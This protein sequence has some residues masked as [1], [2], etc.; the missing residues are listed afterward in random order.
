MLLSRERKVVLDLTTT[1]TT[2][3]PIASSTLLLRPQYNGQWSR[4]IRRPAR[5]SDI[6]AMSNSLSTRSQSRTSPESLFEPSI[7]S[8]QPGRALARSNLHL[9]G[10]RGVQECWTME[11]PSTLPFP[12]KE[13]LTADLAQCLVNTLTR[14]N[15]LYLDELKHMLEER[16]GVS[17]NDSTIWR[18]LQR[19][20]FRMKEVRVIFAFSSGFN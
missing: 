7:V 20:G 11:I 13:P 15:D 18:T 12:V 16:C 9:K 17:V 1:T 4:I 19:V 14:R 5:C 10:N 8:S 3:A 2:T 6:H